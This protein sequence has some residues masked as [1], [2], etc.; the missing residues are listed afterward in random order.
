MK[1]S[2]K[3]FD[4][5]AKIYR[6]LEFFAFGR[7]LERA[8]FAGF[9][10]LRNCR[11]IL[12]LGEGDGRALVRLLRTAPAAKIHCIDASAA[13]LAEAARRLPP[14]DRARVTFQHADVLSTEFPAHAFDAVTT[15][16][17]LDCFTAEEV[18]TTVARIHDAL[19]PD[20]RWLF[21]DFALPARG[22]ARFRARVWLRVLYAFFR[23]RTDLSARSLPPSEAMISAL[24][25]R[26]IAEWEFQDGL[27]R[28]VVFNHPGVQT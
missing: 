6:A 12:V 17:F 14:A 13:M 23:W 16:F 3:G 26:K 4:G 19:R 15:V 25:W 18:R 7:D 2:G 27:V 20:G 8:R 11:C 28:S 1:P 24:G 21:V 22:F 10:Q 9:D 5:L